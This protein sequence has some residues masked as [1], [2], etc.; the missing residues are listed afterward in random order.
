MATLAA[1]LPLA[2]GGTAPVQKKEP[3]IVVI[4]EEFY[5]VAL[6]LKVAVLKEQLEAP[7]APTPKPVAPVVVPNIQPPA[8]TFPWAMV[9]AGLGLVLVVGGTF[10]YLNR[11]LLFKK[12]IQQTPAVVET[13]PP[14]APP[15]APTNLVATSSAGAV[16]LSWVDTSGEEIGYRVER[17]DAASAGVFIPLTNLGA[18]STAFLDPSVQPSMTYAYRV[19]ATNAGGESAPSNEMSVTMAAAPVVE[20]PRPTLPPGGLDSDSDG[21]SDVEEALYG[22]DPRNPET[23]GDSHLDGNEVFH[24]YNPAA[25]APGKLIDSGLVRLVTSPIG[26]SLFVPKAWMEHPDVSNPSK[27]VIDTTHGETFSLFLEQNPSHKAL[28]DWY[29]EMRQSATGT[30]RDV[31][32][33]GGLQGLV[34]ADQLEVFFAWQDKVFIIRYD[35]NGQNF[36]NFRTTFEMMLNSLQLSGAPVVPTT[37]SPITDGPGAL[38]EGSSSSTVAAPVSVTTTATTTTTTSALPITTSSTSSSSATSTPSSTP[39]SATP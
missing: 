37:L 9:A 21:L 24:L 1:P 3:E 5:G 26:W 18:N 27:T 13:P 38:L 30:L 10:I 15:T 35:L 28:R 39:S 23:D 36:I 20:P 16:A 6:K 11:D 32:T 34:G 22:T 14:P 25:R 29:A 19:V 17:R 31:T 33:K 7:V 4:P 8:K 2:G 12:P